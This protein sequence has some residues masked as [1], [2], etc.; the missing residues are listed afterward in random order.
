MDSSWNSL[1]FPLWR[2][3]D[4]FFFLYFVLQVFY[5]WS[6]LFLLTQVVI[7]DVLNLLFWFTSKLRFFLFL[8]LFLRKLKLSGLFR[9]LLLRLCFSW[10][11]RLHWRLWCN[12]RVNFCW[13]LNFWF[14]FGLYLNWGVLFFFLII[15]GA[16]WSSINVSTEVC[17]YL[18]IRFELE[19][20]AYL[21]LCRLW[22]R[23][24]IL[25]RINK[26]N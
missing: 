1:F 20:L 26:T 11:F 2:R 3:T 10:R 17:R 12:L 7:I 24:K 15:Y 5:L 19:I 14:L 18:W 9:F 25:L 16:V 21:N 8:F 13:R 22:L 23:T 6:V 4:L